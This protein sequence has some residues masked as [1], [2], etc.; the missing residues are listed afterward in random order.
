MA[1]I[2]SREISIQENIVQRKVIFFKSSFAINI[3]RNRAEKIK[4]QMDVQKIFF[5]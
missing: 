3:I 1:Y 5:Y 4:N 2:L